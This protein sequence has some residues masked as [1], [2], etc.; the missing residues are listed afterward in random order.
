MK[1]IFYSI[2]LCCIGM[3]L[4]TCPAHAQI[5][6]SDLQRL[7]SASIVV[8]KLTGGTTYEGKF[9][10]Q[11]SE[12]LVLNLPE[13]GDMSFLFAD[14]RTI[15]IKGFGV[16]NEGAI[17]VP[18]MDSAQTI[19]VSLNDGSILVGTLISQSSSEI[20]L[21]NAT[22]GR[23]T[24]SLSQVK[25]VST[26]KGKKIAG[27]S[28]WMPNPHPTRYFFA[29]SAFNLKKG[30]GYYQNVS[31]DVNLVSY[32]ITDWFSMGGGLELVWTLATLSMGDWSPLWVLTPKIGFPVGKNLH[33]GAGFIGGIYKS[34]NF[35][36]SETKS[37]A[38]GL[39]IT[40]GVATYGSIENNITVGLGLPM[41]TQVKK[42]NPP[43]IVLNGMYRV[44]PKIS[45]I[46]E[47]WIFTGGNG[48]LDFGSIFGY[49]IR[50]L[51]ES[52][53]F[54]FGFM[55]NKNIASIFFIGVPY[56]DFVYKFGPK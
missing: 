3:V 48:V 7:D 19:S 23:T 40:Y 14:I 5:K 34:F 41:S 37:P 50:L 15:E 32:G 49:G 25:S 6:S 21:S 54:D 1:T 47:N 43:I 38:M 2:V 45:L 35:G 39:G 42:V 12:R 16:I 9:V 24:I 55:N 13:K 27:L 4:I 33:L 36:F 28:A 30:E 11:T 10:R 56:V 18:H 17:S 26:S 46:S 51:A 53:S 29:P 31:V 22:T 20:V 8:V 44:S 52:M